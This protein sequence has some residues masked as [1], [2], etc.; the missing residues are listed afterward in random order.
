MQFCIE[1]LEYVNIVVIS[2]TINTTY[3]QEFKLSYLDNFV[4]KTELEVE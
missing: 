4:W 1:V 2:E 3:H